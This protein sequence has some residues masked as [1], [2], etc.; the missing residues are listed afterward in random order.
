MKVLEKTVLKTQYGMLEVSSLLLFT[1]AASGCSRTQVQAAPA[2]P[3]P[4]VTIAN[5]TAQD[6]P[7]YFDEIGLKAEGPGFEQY[8]KEGG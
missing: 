2:M 1:F 7:Q 6:V 4:L 3:A 8:P 5:A